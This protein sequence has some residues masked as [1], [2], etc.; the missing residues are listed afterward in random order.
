MVSKWT[1]GTIKIEYSLI[2][3]DKNVPPTPMN[4]EPSQMRLCDRNI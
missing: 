3:S 1:P 2:V 4:D